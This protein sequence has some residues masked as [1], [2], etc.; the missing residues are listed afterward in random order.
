MALGADRPKVVGLVLQGAFR[1]VVFGLVLGLPL[2]VAA[3]LL[4]A[5]LFGV[6]FWDPMALGVGAVSLVICAF[7]AAI[8]PATRAASISP[9]G[10]CESTDPAVRSTSRTERGHVNHETVASH[11]S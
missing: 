11:R 4:S 5:Q 2:A 10:R 1:R 8:V 7:V 6:R 9:I 3:G